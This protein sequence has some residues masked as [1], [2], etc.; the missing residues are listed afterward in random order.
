[1][2]KLEVAS[3]I[4]LDT[5]DFTKKSIKK[6]SKFSLKWL[7]LGI[8]S[9]VSLLSIDYVIHADIYLQNNIQPINLI[10]NNNQFNTHFLHNNV[11][12]NNNQDYILEDQKMKSKQHN[13]YTPIVSEFYS[14][15]SDKPLIS[16][17]AIEET[18]NNLSSYYKGVCDTG[19]ISRLICTKYNTYKLLKF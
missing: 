6:G 17:S 19:I 2:K 5:F 15:Y 10:L 9:S 7:A 14:P 18:N 12:L 16:E 1:M 4:M 8:F 3:Y 11:S 13:T